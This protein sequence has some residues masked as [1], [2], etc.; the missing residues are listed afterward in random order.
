MD[1]TPCLRQDILS[2]CNNNDDVK[3]SWEFISQDEHPITGEPSFFLH[4]CQTSARLAKLQNNSSNPDANDSAVVPG[5]LLLSW[6]SMILP[7]VRSRISSANYSRTHHHLLQLA[8]NDNN[9]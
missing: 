2:Y 9:G 3:D 8:A 1:G 6:L 7:A 5:T 4:P